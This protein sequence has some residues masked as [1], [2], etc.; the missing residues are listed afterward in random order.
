MSQE[1]KMEASSL[2]SVKIISRETIKPSSKTKDL[3]GQIKLSY[4]D[5]LLPP[6]HI[7]LILFY[8]SRSVPEPEPGLSASTHSDISQLL[9]Q[10]LSTTLTSFYPLAG[11]TNENSPLVHCN[12]A[13]V[14]FLDARDHVHLVD[15][16]R[17]PD[18]KHLNWYLPPT[19]PL[20]GQGNLL[21]VKLTFFDCGGVALGICISHKFTDL[22]SL[23]AFLDAW[24]GATRG[25]C[26]PKPFTFDLSHYFPPRTDIHGGARLLGMSDEND[27]TKRFI[28]GKDMLAVLKETAVSDTMTN[29]TKVEVISAFFWQHLIRAAKSANPGGERISSLIH[30]VNLRPRTNPAG[31]MENVYGNCFMQA[32]A[33][34]DTAKCN[35]PLSSLVMALR[36]SFNR[37]NGDYIAQS[38]EGDAYKDDLQKWNTMFLNGELMEACTF[39]SW[40]QF[41]MYSVDFG[42]GKPVYACIAPFI[43][44]KNFVW[45]VNTRCGEGV[46]AWVTMDKHTVEEIE[47]RFQLLSAGS[48]SC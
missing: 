42:W 8:E 40:C 45:L 34:H 37:I 10:S 4:L 19:P 23:N 27:V 16:V 3:Q 28:F 20:S 17:D 6:M 48:S 13:G 1:M 44:M 22:I 15:V 14:E 26:S 24:T 39:S 47:A 18:L 29:P 35:N 41:S 21:A 7:P 30:A 11:S 2:S 5:Q 9:K 33:L 36:D 43:S 12:D 32:M 25:Q 46:E 38:Q 31:M